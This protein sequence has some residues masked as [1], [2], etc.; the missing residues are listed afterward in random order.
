MLLKVLYFIPE[1]KISIMFYIIAL[2]DH[3]LN[4]FFTTKKIQQYL[5]QSSTSFK[6]KQDQQS[7]KGKLVCCN[8][9]FIRYLRLKSMAIGQAL[10]VKYRSFHQENYKRSE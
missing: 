10:S 9:I 8:K 6:T 7:I 5:K 3:S 1:F 4:C 2:P